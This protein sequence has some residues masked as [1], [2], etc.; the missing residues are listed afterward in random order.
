MFA[1]EH[2]NQNIIGVK[3]VL[4]N[5][6][7]VDKLFKICHLPLNDISSSHRLPTI[8]TKPTPQV[9]GDTFFSLAFGLESGWPR[10]NKCGCVSHRQK[11]YDVAT[12]A[13]TCVSRC[14]GCHLSL[15]TQGRILRTE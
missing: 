12:R 2:I 14:L 3:D 1:L 9:D 8:F 5:L 11:R 4:V 13:T 10:M 15:L 7:E 6:V